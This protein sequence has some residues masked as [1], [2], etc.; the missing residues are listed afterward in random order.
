MQV[1]VVDARVRHTRRFHSFLCSKKFYRLFLPTS[2][3]RSLLFLQSYVCLVSYPLL[4]SR[5]HSRFVRARACPFILKRSKPNVPFFPSSPFDLP[6]FFRRMYFLS[7]SFFEKKKKKKNK[8]KKTPPTAHLKFFSLYI[9]ISIPVYIYTHGCVIARARVCIYIYI[10]AA[11]SY[12]IGSL[13]QFSFSSLSL[14]YA[15]LEF[16]QNSR[17]LASPLERV[18]TYP[19][20]KPSSRAPGSSPRFPSPRPLSSVTRYFCYLFYYFS[21][22][23]PAFYRPVFVCFLLMYTCPLEIAY[24]TLLLEIIPSFVVQPPHPPSPPLQPLVLS[25]PT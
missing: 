9:F 20:N 15:S 8:K 23:P 10:H 16:P 25:L 11:F 5:L 21:F 14:L 6:A 19:I 3:F 17:F 1:N 18:D 4:P 24:I 13:S 7:V 22:F 12:R 2:P